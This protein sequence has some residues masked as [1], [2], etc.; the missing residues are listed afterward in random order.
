M[1]LAS[2]NTFGAEVWSDNKRIAPMLPEISYIQ[3]CQH[4]GKYFITSRQEIV[5]DRD[6]RT[7]FEQ[8]ILSYDEMKEAFAQICSE[9]FDDQDEEAS[10]RMMMFHAFNDHYHRRACDELP[11]EEDVTLFREQG[12]WLLDNIITDNVLKAEFYREISE[13]QK[14]QEIIDNTSPDEDFLRNIMQQIKERVQANDSRVFKL[15]L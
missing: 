12:L 10:V 2:G 1:T 3:K 13:M 6:G 7:S 4:C 15:K 11:S 8:G 5:Y 14:A 9:G